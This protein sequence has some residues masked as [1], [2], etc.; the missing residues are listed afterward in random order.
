MEEGDLAFPNMP[1]VQLRAP[2]LQ[3]QVQETPLLAIVNFQ[4]L[5]ATKASRVVRAA[6]GDKVL[7]FGLRRAQGVDSALSASR[8]AYI[9]GVDGASNVLAGKIWGIPVKGTHAHAWVMTFPTEIEAFEAYA[10]TMTINCTFLVDT[11]DTIQGVK[12]AIQVGF[13]LK[14]KGYQLAGIRLDSGDMTRLSI[15]ARKL[16]DEA[17]FWMPKL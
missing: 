10:N 5:I 6:D 4:T 1:L 11:Y 8:A 9:G 16:L 15:E 13:K 17:G 2:L 7:E 14:E 12:N 3:A